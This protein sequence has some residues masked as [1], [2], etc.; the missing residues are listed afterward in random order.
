MRTL[1]TLLA[2]ALATAFT[3]TPALASDASLR[4]AIKAQERSLTAASE[5]FNEVASDVD[6][7]VGREK[8]ATATTRLKAAVA[9]LRT[10]ITKQ[11][12]DSA[13]VK[14]GRTAYL[15][16]LT[17]FRTGL[18]TFEAGLR[19]FDPDAPAKAATL[20]DKSAAQLK[21]AGKALTAAEKQ[22][23]V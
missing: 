15:A 4:K 3:A 19:A 14:S 22:L 21:S 17:R 13:K 11:K 18:S 7:A 16:G 23:G 5:A 12:A 20:F 8:A 6:S 1:M 10:A 2:V 9:K